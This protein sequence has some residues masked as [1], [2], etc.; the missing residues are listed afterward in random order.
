MQRAI[1]R[2][3]LAAMSTAC[4]VAPASAQA[5]G[6]AAVV[7]L[8]VRPGVTMR[9]LALA[10]LNP[11]LAA[12]ILFTGGPGIANIPDNPDPNW[13]SRGNF[14]V[15]SRELFRG[16]RLFVAVVDA[17]SD[18][19]SE[20][21]LGHFRV[22][23]EHAADIALLIADV[24]KRSAGI[25]VWLVGTSMGTISAASAAARLQ[26]PSAA[27]GLVLS[28]TVTAHPSG[29]HPPP[30]VADGMYSLDLEAI[31]VPTLLVY[32]RADA[33][34]RT[35]PSDVPKLERSLKGAPRV[36]VVAIDGGD[37]PISDGCGPLDAHGF[38]GREAAA[39][40][41]IADWILQ[42]KPAQ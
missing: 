25:P 16:H 32:N 17:P 34:N 19:K 29:K 13:A 42:P 21:G 10:P 1:K 27:D 14:L 39:V 9:Y 8:A 37:K 20:T 12:V 41:A 11:P 38:L 22:S 6:K 26:A 33:C 23:G 5:P 2:M 4:L 3:I 40:T 15:R 30:D 18:H 28:S 36:A 7:D 24:R 35:P 31:R